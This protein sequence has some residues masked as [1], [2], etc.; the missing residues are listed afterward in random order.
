M[1]NNIN[2]NYTCYRLDI[3]LLLSWQA[4]HW[5]QVIDDLS[6]IFTISVFDNILLPDTEEWDERL[7]LKNECMMFN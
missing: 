2:M 3:S 7:L 5:L 6:S 1:I 4:F